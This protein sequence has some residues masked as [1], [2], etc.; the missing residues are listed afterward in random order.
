MRVDQIKRLVELVEKSDIGELEVREWGRSIRIAKMSRLGSQVREEQ[1]S[2]PDEIVPAQTKA[3]SATEPVA[4][5]ETAGVDLPAEETDDGLEQIVS[6][7]VGTFYQSSSPTASPYVEV[8]G[9]VKKGQVVGIVEAMKL[10]NEIE[11]EL[12]GIVVKIVVKNEQPVEFN[13]PLFLIK[14]DN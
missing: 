5:A 9:R 1:I 14:P 13:Q 12:A 2:P 4:E 11:S 3:A 10:M 8:G 6:P 7:M